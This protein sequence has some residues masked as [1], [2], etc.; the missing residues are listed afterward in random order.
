MPRKMGFDN[1][2]T[3]EIYQ[4][5][6]NHIENFSEELVRDFAEKL[7]ERIRAKIYIGWQEVTPEYNRMRFE[8]ELLAANDKYESLNLDVDGEL[9]E[10]LMN[11]II[12][13][14]SLN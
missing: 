6:K 5:I 13:N 7:T 10:K 8:V 12:D 4:T 14:F 11:S 9:G 3:F 1:K 2:V